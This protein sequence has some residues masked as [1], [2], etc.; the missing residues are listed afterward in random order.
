MFCKSIR[1]LFDWIKK[2]LTPQ[3][4][5]S[6]IEMQRTINDA[7][8]EYF[9]IGENATEEAYRDAYARMVSMKTLWQWM[10]PVNYS[11]FILNTVYF[12]EK[13]D[14]VNKTIDLLEQIY[15]DYETAC[16]YDYANKS[17]IHEIWARLYVEENVE[18]QAYEHL[19]KSAFYVFID[20]ISYDGFEYFSFR[21]FSDY[22][23]ADIKNNTICLAHPSTFNDPM[24]TILLRWNQHLLESSTDETEREL[25]TI[26]QKVYD[27]LKV[28]CFVRTDRLP[29]DARFDEEPPSCKKQRIEDINPLMWAHY[30]NDHKG[31]CIKYKLPGTIVRN[32]DV[33]S[34]TWTRIGNV[35]YQPSM[36]IGE[37]QSFDVF[38]ALFAKHDIWSYENE[39][40][41][42]QYDP[43]NT[44]NFK[45]IEVPEDSIQSIYLG[46]KCSDEDRKKMKLV[47]RNRNIKLYQMEVDATD[48]YKMT[49]K[50]IF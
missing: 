1:H 4:G 40:R 14:G 31:F 34:L 49:K 42:I 13:Y 10:T 8:A 45:T 17:K 7:V 32:E 46:L 43:N 30:A 5:M 50:R 48:N 33:A 20:N 41:L 19:K 9:D 38:D 37:K 47:L 11:A 18:N 21:S 6:I 15:P 24:D 3:K 16:P 23:L 2:S 27:H 25:R 29:R 36:I 26:Y 22:A 35:D 44:D 39:V 28:R 12:S